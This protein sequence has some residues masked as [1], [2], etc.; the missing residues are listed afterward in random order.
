M[1]IIQGLRSLGDTVARMHLKLFLD[2]DPHKFNDVGSSGKKETDGLI[3]GVEMLMD[4]IAGHRHNITSLPGIS[5]IVMDFVTF[6]VEDIKN[7]L[8]IMAVPP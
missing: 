4:A 3:A 8:V 2:T 7:G 6:P 5:D 1:R